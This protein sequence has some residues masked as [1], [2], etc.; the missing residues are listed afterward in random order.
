VDVVYTHTWRPFEVEQS[1]SFTQRSFG[2]WQ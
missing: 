2:V 1:L